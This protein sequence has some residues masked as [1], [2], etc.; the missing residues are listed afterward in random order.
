M[1]CRRRWN[2]LA[3][4][5]SHHF[6]LRLGSNSCN[7]LQRDLSGDG[8]V[9]PLSVIQFL[10]CAH[11]RRR[12]HEEAAAARSTEATD[13]RSEA[14]EARPGDAGKALDRKEL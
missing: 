3:I 11:S 12:T 14:S 4:S 13:G 10:Q 1:V 9:F 6:H 2:P 8:D 5:P 7:R